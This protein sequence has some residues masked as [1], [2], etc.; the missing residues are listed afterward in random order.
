MSVDYQMHLRQNFERPEVTV[1][2]ALDCWY[3]HYMQGNATFF[4]GVETHA[5]LYEC[6][7]VIEVHKE[8]LTDETP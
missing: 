1:E 8:Y 6:L 4:V 2:Y 3:R 7:R 5:G